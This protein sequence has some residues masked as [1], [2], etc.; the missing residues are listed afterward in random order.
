MAVW[1]L[2]EEPGVPMPLSTFFKECFQLKEGIYLSQRD[3]LEW[4]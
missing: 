4:N 1:R 2:A 3:A